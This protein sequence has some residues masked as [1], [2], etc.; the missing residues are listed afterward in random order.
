[1]SSVIPSILTAAINSA[2]HS[3]VGR[4]P[5]T[6]EARGSGLV[7]PGLGSAVATFTLVLCLFPPQRLQPE[8]LGP[9]SVLSTSTNSEAADTALYLTLTSHTRTRAI[10][11]VGFALILG[12]CAGVMTVEGLRRWRRFHQA[13]AVKAKRLGLEEFLQTPLQPAKPEELASGTRAAIHAPDLAI[14]PTVA[15]P[16]PVWHGSDPLQS[17]DVPYGLLSETGLP[18]TGLPETGLPETAEPALAI[19][20]VEAAALPL[21]PDQPVQLLISRDH[22]QSCHVHL[23]NCDRRH[24]AI[25]LSPA[26]MF[27]PA[28]SLEST[29]PRYYTFVRRQPTRQR[30]WQLASRLANQGDRLVITPIRSGYA[31]WRWEAQAYPE[32]TEPVAR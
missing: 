5:G 27:K 21:A 19:P 32:F 14:A 20:A 11:Q 18:E 29:A 12:V 8:A 2:I 26:S 1:M 24:F 16:L 7:L 6:Q 31:L 22:Y 23:P 10:R 25:A 28:A 15:E 30:A 4:S 17:L 3:T 9:R 13:G